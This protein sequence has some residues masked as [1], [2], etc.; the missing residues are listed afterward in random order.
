MPLSTGARLGPYEIVNRAG[1]GG[2]G[3]VWKAR[4]TRLNRTVAIK[5]L[6]PDLTTDPA[7]RQRPERE[8]RAVAALSHPH[9]CPLFD[10]GHQDGPTSS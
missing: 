3:E 10:I 6:P 4:D 8:A 9:I 1:A 5:V 7:A 2:R